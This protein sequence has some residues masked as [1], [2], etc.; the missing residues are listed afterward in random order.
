MYNESRDMGANHLPAVN[1]SSDLRCVWEFNYQEAA[2]FLQEGE[3]NDK[4]TTHPRTHN[5]VPAYYLAHSTWLYVFDLFA[6]VLILLLALCEGDQSV[7]YLY[8]PV[9][10]SPVTFGS[11]YPKKRRYIQYEIYYNTYIS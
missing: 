3:N 11:L 10:V 9:G 5:S 7:S 8:L 4:Y 6:T 2:I 1:V